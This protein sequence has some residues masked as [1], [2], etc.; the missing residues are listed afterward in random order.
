MPESTKVYKATEDHVK[1]IGRTHHYKDVLWLALSGGGVEFSFYGKK[2]E[3]TLQGDAI[4][5]TGN[6]QARRM[7]IPHRRLRAP[8]TVHP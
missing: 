8:A 5:S 7:R 6:N 1:I 4:A 2:A 3:I